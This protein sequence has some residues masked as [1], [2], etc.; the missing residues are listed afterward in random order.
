V[1]VA[2]PQRVG[3]RFADVPTWRE[4]GIN[5][6]MPSFRMFVGAKGLSGPQLRYWDGVFGKLAASPEWKKELADN[7]WQGSYMNSAD[8]LRYLDAQAQSYRRILGEL[9]LAKR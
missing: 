3:G 6:V 2:A 4:Q 7:E 5:A 9:G 8:S 1:A